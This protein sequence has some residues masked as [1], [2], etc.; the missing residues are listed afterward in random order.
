M[1]VKKVTFALNP[2]FHDAITQKADERAMS[3]QN[4]STK[5]SDNESLPH[6]QPKKSKTGR[7]KKVNNKF[8]QYF[9]RDR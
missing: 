1:T 7:L 4:T 6:C 5:Y 8:I 3:I 9:T 2:K